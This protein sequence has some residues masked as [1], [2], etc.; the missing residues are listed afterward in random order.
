MRRYYISQ[1]LLH[2][3]VLTDVHYMC[4]CGGGGGGGYSAI[5]QVMVKMYLT[6]SYDNGKTMMPMSW[7]ENDEN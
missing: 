5:I 3:C 2:L 1:R 7:Q 4:V 6:P